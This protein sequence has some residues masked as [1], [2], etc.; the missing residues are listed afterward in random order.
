M[1]DF[2][3]FVKKANPRYF[4]Y[5]NDEDVAA[6]LFEIYFIRASSERNRN[7]WNIKNLI[8]LYEAYKL[9]KDIRIQLDI[10]EAFTIKKMFSAMGSAIGRGFGHIIPESVKWF[11][12]N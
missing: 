3:K 11:Y 7:N 9:N 12:R 1:T 2:I 10:E 4:K 8:N 5:F 6:V